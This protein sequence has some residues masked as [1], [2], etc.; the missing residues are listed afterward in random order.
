MKK[1]NIKAPRRDAKL[2]NLPEAQR[3]L[4]VEWHMEDGDGDILSYMTKD[5]PTVTVWEFSELVN[6]SDFPR[7]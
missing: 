3:A 7:Q 1:Q 4:I 5:G 2:K 6:L